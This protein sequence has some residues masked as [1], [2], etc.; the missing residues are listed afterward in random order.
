MFVL[1]VHLHIFGEAF[2]LLVNF[3]KILIFHF[4]CVCAHDGRE[5]CAC[6]CMYPQNPEEGIRVE[7]PVTGSGEAPGMGFWN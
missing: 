7:S 6:R 3:F 1:T 2:R 4:V 5:V